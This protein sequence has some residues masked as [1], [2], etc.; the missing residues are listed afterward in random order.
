VDALSKLARRPVVRGIV[1]LVVCAAV[2]LAGNSRWSVVDSDEARFSLAVKEMRERGEWVL[3]T[4]WGEP[5]YHKP[6]LTYWLA[7]GAERLLGPGETALRLPSVLAGLLSVW[8]TAAL[9]AHWL[10]RAVA[11]RAGFVLATS[12]L[13]VIESKACTADATLLASTLASLY[14]WARLRDGEGRVWPWQLLLWGGVG[15]GLL[16]KVVNVG[17][18]AAIACA[19]LVLRGGLGLRSR[20]ALSVL[21]VGGALAAALPVTAAGGTIVVAVVFLWLGLDSLRTSAGRAGWSKLGAPWGVPLALAMAALW[22]VPALARSQGA[23][24]TVGAGHHLFGRLLE[25]FEGHWGPPGYYAFLLPLIALPWGAS[26]PVALREAWR[27]RRADPIQ[28]ILLAWILGPWVLLELLPSKLPHYLLLTLPAVA[29]VVAVEWQRRVDEKRWPTLGTRRAEAAL[30]ALFGVAVALAA[31]FLA[32]KVPSGAMK[33]AA[34]AVAAIALAVLAGAGASALVRARAR[35][36][37]LL[38]GGTAAL[39]IA[40]AGALLPALEP[41]RLAPLLGAAVQQHLPPGGSV[42]VLGPNAASIGYYLPAGTR[43]A[44][45]IAD[46]VS[47]L[48]RPGDAA[49]VVARPKDLPALD[50]ALAEAGAAP[51]QRIDRVRGAIF[52]DLAPRDVWLL[53]AGA[54]NDPSG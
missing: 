45:S 6:I 37:P 36:F 5:R 49:I 20:R 21:L 53:R 3:P 48:T 51:L 30:V 52:P 32:W 35:A 26:L 13:F 19:L 31:G 40:L 14:G 4:N 44:R 41:I 12:L 24:A 22:A 38:V 29:L 46:A 43:R 34:V 16:S 50:A 9:G 28:E 8:L 25:P 39:W 7:L 23:F 11:W 33:L 47:A 27:R 2:L 10:G 42:W 17:F 18:L 15:V 1:L 54:P